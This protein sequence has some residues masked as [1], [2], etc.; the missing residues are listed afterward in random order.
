MIALTSSGG[1]LPI[2]I[3]S[4]FIDG[5]QLRIFRASGLFGFVLSGDWRDR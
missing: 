1:F 3:W 5:S 2:E 4:R